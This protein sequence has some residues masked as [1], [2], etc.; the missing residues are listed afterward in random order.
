MCSL[1][2]WHLIQHDGKAFFVRKECNS[3]AVKFVVSDLVYVWLTEIADDDLLILFQKLNPFIECRDYSVIHKMID[4]C[5]VEGNKEHPLPSLEIAVLDDDS[6]E[7]KFKMMMGGLLMKLHVNVQRDTPLT[8]F[9]EITLPT[10]QIGEELLMRQNLLC[11]SLEKKDAEISQYKLEGA[12]LIRT[13]VETKPFSKDEFLYK[14]H[15]HKTCI[16]SQGLV[17]VSDYLNLFQNCNPPSINETISVANPPPC[18]G[19]KPL[20]NQIGASGSNFTSEVKSESD[21]KLLTDC[22]PSISEANKPKKKKPKLNL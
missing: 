7:L 15:A 11:S 5:F 12:T 22:T 21:V 3:S 9:K 19:L 16:L 1:S 13:V 8:F 2:R 10:L 4:S 20:K 6:I 14:R 18:S 17:N